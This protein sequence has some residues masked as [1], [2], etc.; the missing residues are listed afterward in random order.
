MIQNDEFTCHAIVLRH[1]V[2]RITFRN[3]LQE[4]RVMTNF[5]KN[6]QLFFDQKE[7]IILELMN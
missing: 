5:S 3:Q 4:K 1:K 7:K 6:R 2:N